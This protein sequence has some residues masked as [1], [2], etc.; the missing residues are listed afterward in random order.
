MYSTSTSGRASARFGDVGDIERLTGTLWA[1]RAAAR[2]V[3]EAKTRAGRS[4]GEAREKGGLPV[5]LETILAT[6]PV[7]Q[8]GKKCQPNNFFIFFW[9]RHTADL[10]W[11]PHYLEAGGEGEEEY[12]ADLLHSCLFTH[13]LVGNNRGWGLRVGRFIHSHR[14]EVTE[15]ALKSLRPVCKA[16]GV[17]EGSAL[18][19]SEILWSLLWGLSMVDTAVYQNVD[20]FGWSG[21]GRGLLTGRPGMVV[22]PS[23]RRGDHHS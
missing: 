7:T 5:G 8:E 13:D 6:R 20:I 22:T 10:D 18:R 19:T 14:A 4:S 9:W 12:V 23:L 1:K 3:A 21:G 2:A 11:G 15:M 17:D 16:S